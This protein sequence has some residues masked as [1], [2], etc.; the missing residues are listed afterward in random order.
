M[1]KDTKKKMSSS[2]PRQGRWGEENTSCFYHAESKTMVIRESNDVVLWKY[3]EFRPK[4]L[5]IY[6]GGGNI[7]VS[8]D[9]CKLAVL[10][11]VSIDVIQ[12]MSAGMYYLLSNS[13]TR[14]WKDGEYATHGPGISGDEATWGSSIHLGS[15]QVSRLE[16][17]KHYF[18]EYKV[19]KYAK[20]WYS[21]WGTKTS[22]ANWAPLG[23]TPGTFWV[24]FPITDL[25][26]AEI[27]NKE[28]TSLLSAT[29]SESLKGG[30]DE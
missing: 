8:T 3:L 22:A 5:V 2:S 25:A 9:I 14:Y 13:P 29:R 11:N 28:I 18:S 6:G 4:R 19:S 20:F 24:D 30:N 17:L 21:H 1:M 12:A 26:L 15:Q 7:A 27:P 23:R 16:R 10:D